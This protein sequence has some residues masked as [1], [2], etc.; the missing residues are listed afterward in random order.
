MEITRRSTLVEVCFTVCTALQHTG[1]IAV[2]TGGSAAVYYA[3]ERYQSADADFIVTW[4][5]NPR[6]AAS[7]LRELGFIEK[8]GLYH[9]PE[10]PFALEFPP[11][12]LSIGETIVRNYETIRRGDHVL[13]VLSRTDSVCD[14]LAAFYHWG[15]RSSLRT[16]LDVARSGEIDLKSVASW[17][18]REGASEKFA[19]FVRRYH[20]ERHERG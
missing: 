20:E 10:T 12:P 18:E 9:H 14:R 15:D 4:N 1:A 2:L 8:A 16:A 7:A 11:G 3:P 6:A 5:Q 13:H 19:E 17:S